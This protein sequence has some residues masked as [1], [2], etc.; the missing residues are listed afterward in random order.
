MPDLIARPQF[1]LANQFMVRQDTLNNAIT[2]EPPPT[3]QPQP[4][5]STPLWCKSTPNGSN[6]QIFY[7]SSTGKALYFPSF[8]IDKD[9]AGKW[10]VK[11]T[12]PDKSRADTSLTITLATQ[13]ANDGQKAIGAGVCP[14]PYYA[15]ASGRDTTAVQ[16]N[17]IGGM[18]QLTF[19][20]ITT[21]QDGKLVCVANMTNPTT[22]GEVM[23]ALVNHNAD[24]NTHASLTVTRTIAAVGVAAGTAPAPPVTPGGIRPPILIDRPAFDRAMV[25][26]AAA[27]PAQPVATRLMVNREMFLNPGVESIDIAGEGQMFRPLP[28]LP[29]PFPIPDPNPPGTPLYTL[30]SNQKVAT[31]IPDVWFLDTLSADVISDVTGVKPTQAGYKRYPV[32]GD[33]TV[34]QDLN[35]LTSFYYLPDAFKIARRGTPPFLPLLNVTITG[36]K[37]DDAQATVFFTALPVVDMQQLRAA[38]ALIQNDNHG[39]TITMQPLPTPKDIHYGLYLPGLP[40]ASSFV[41]RAVPVALDQALTDSPQLS[42]DHFQTA[43]MSLTAPL[44]QYLQGKI[45][46][47][48]GE[49]IV[50]VPLIARADDFPGVY[51][52]QTRSIDGAA[53]AIKLALIN[54]VENPVQVDALPLVA[55][56][57]GAPVNCSVI[58]DPP[59]PAKIA[60][61]DDSHLAGGTLTLTITPA[62]G[63]LDDTLDLVVDQSHCRVVPDAAGL[64]RAVLDPSVPVKASTPVTVLVPAVLFGTDTDPAKKILIITMSFLNGNTIRFSR[65]ADQT[66]AVVSPDQAGQVNLTV[67]DYLLRQAGGATSTIKYKLAITYASGHTIN[68]T[69]W[70]IAP[71]DNF[72]LDLP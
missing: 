68:D 19:D 14:A 58:Y 26:P 38:R 60:A 8:V 17:Y 71:N 37:I 54:S 46:V 65:P 4:I 11:F 69:D 48:I 61:A 52:Q 51:F 50:E 62:S 24:P 39:Q 33:R 35:D 43:F 36:T 55:T 56:R 30:L 6:D 70:R 47:P 29:G 13:P 21:D 44:S 5:G 53:T 27:A 18:K 22:V 32:S 57:A 28:P 7:E 2:F 72:V 20:Q 23:G 66:V 59:L 64:L 67:F 63:P 3:R 9:I 34:F 31:T 41:S 40:D 12:Q 49:T 25:E 16:L 10:R 1:L 45:I 15:D 42:L